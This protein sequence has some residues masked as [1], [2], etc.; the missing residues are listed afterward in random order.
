MKKLQ[1]WM[2]VIVFTL[3]GA[4]T[5]GASPLQQDSE[6]AIPPAVVE[7]IP[8]EGEELLL[9]QTITF[10]F[11]QAMDRA[12]VEAAFSVEPETGSLGEL[13]WLDDLSL[14]VSPQGEW[15]RDAE[16][17]F[18]IDVTATSAEGVPLQD[19]YEITFNTVG[20]LE[21]AE[22]LPAD[23]QTEIDT[24]SLITVIFNR[25][26]V[27]L[28]SIE[29]QQDLP[30]P[31]EISPELNGTGEWLN[32]S[33]YVFR[34][35]PGLLGGLDHTVTV[36]AGLTDVTGAVLREDFSWT[37]ST[38]QPEI[39]DVSPGFDSGN[40][41]LE[42]TVS[43]YFS[44][45][46]N[47]ATTSDA[48]SLVDS[49][50]V[51]VEGSFEWAE[52]NRSFV[53]TPVD[54]LVLDTFYTISISVDVATS[55]TG[56]RLEDGLTSTFSTVPYPAIVSTRPANGESNASPYGGFEVYFNVPIDIES[57]EGKFTVVPEPWREY[58]NYYYD[59]NYRYSL[60]FD[61]EPSTEYSVTIAPGIADPYGNTID[62]ALVV[63]YTTGAYD[64][65]INLNIPGFVGLYSAYNPNTRV[66]AT[67]RN[68][69]RLN[70]ELYELS[71]GSLGGFLGD[72]GY[73]FMSD[74]I[75]PR[76]ALLRR[77]SVDVQ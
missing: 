46:M 1:F 24:D 63:T 10:Y 7:T 29:E 48:F 35:D 66:F 56:A 16:L 21:V 39:I 34:P 57:L 50:G 28:V 74:F 36:K 68:V 26:V 65:E 22:V 64:P 6:A 25:P 52:D 62:E 15:S 17:N 4:I 77:W 31:L 18:K 2:I 33:I 30:T 13:T 70:L 45:A 47:V 55:S 53:F 60:F 20:F 38:L 44:Q 32:T 12:S 76:D 11:D 37:F 3:T 72:N 23:G 51:A 75:P 61:T 5:A 69:S 9:D 54:L 19:T 27:P 67:H 14:M 49:N 58:D 59:Y 71:F 41:P 42:T 40:L 8:F 43:V 73:Q